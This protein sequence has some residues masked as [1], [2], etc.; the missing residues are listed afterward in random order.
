MRKRVIL[1]FLIKHLSIAPKSKANA[2]IQCEVATISASPN[3]RD[4]SLSDWIFFVSATGIIGLIFQRSISTKNKWMRVLQTKKQHLFELYQ[5][6]EK[7]LKATIQKVAEKEEELRALKQELEEF[8]IT[9]KIELPQNETNLGLLKLLSEK[10][11]GLSPN[12]KKLALL[13]RQNLDNYDIASVLSIEYNSV[14]MAKTRLKKKLKI[15]GDLYS[16]IQ[17]LI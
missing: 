14:R 6:R 3:E 10:H 16:Y 17:N 2:E 5:K 11:P 4:C 12:E 13:I 15:E 9:S 1:L 7:K 8:K